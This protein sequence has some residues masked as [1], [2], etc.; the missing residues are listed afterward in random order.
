MSDKIKNIGQIDYP[1]KKDKESLFSDSK[2]VKELYPNNFNELDTSKLKDKGCTFI[3]FYAPWCGYCKRSK[4]VWD[5]LAES[6]TFLNI[7]AFNCEKNKS[8]VDKMNID[9]KKNTED[10]LIRG[11][12]TLIMYKNGKPSQFY[13]DEREFENL[14]GFCMKSKSECSK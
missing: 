3:M 6:V 9:H 7:C 4:E 11:Y 8:F 12:P 2:F 13:R 1:N 14:L 10:V 5:K